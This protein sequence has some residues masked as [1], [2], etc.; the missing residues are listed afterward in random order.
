MEPTLY[1]GNHVL[2]KKTIN[3]IPKDN[4][5][6]LYKVARE[7]LRI[8]RFKHM[9]QY[10]ILWSDNFSKYPPVQINEEED[11]YLGKMIAVIN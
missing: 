9:G 7:E 8:K 2:F 1:D 11:Y 4:D 10:A 6:A 5:I 3:E